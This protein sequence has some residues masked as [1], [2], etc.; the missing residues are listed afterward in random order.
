MSWMRVTLSER[1]I[2]A[3]KNTEL[4]KRF[5]V[6]FAAAGTPA[7]AI[8]YGWW[9]ARDRGNYYFTPSASKLA[10]ALLKDYGGVPCSKPDIEGLAVMV[11]TG[12]GG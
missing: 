7:A 11:G 8:M 3:Y 12:A 1:D 4:Q 6:E 5:F 2:V 9:K 10:S